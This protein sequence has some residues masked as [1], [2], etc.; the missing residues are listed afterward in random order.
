[1]RTIDRIALDGS[2]GWKVVVH[3]AECNE[4]GDCPICQTDFGECECPGPTQE[5]EFEYATFGGI[6][7][8]RPIGFQE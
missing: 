6:L 8:A 3:A 5:D 2:D 1:M 7:L 4:D